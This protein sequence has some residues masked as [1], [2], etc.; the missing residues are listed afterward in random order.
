MKTIDLNC[1]MGESFGA[2]T[3]GMDEKVMAH[4]SSA[5][6][7]CGFHAGDPMVMDK[8]VKMAM[9]NNVRI[10]AHPGYP[11]LMGFGRRSMALTAEE[12]K[13]YLVFQVGALM[14]F[15]KVHGTALAHVK[16]HGALYLDAVENKTIARAVAES[17][18]S[19]DPNLYF[20]ALAG[21]KGETMRQVG[22]ELGLKV[23]Y[24]AFPDR[25]YTPE[26]TLVSRK[27]PGAVILDPERVAKRALD[28]ANGFVKSVDGKTIEL[29]V[30]TLCVHGDNLLAVDLVKTIKTTLK[31][32]SITI[33]SMG[34]KN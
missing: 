11:D 9:A 10:G 33:K 26:G 27:E 22:E 7:A 32:N 18:L 23:V 17:I 13:Q 2:Y 1:D 19:L 6:I 12:I 34:M 4:I 21:K 16:P 30:Q 14:A 24:E 5:N 31:A 29:D 25:A 28:M 20:V 8:T 15:C 3:I